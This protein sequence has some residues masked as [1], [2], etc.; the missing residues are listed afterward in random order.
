MA[1]FWLK[2]TGL[3][4]RFVEKTFFVKSLLSWVI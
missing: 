1:A 2:W 3:E 4:K